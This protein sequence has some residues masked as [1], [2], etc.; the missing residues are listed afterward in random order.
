[1]SEQ[2]LEKFHAIEFGL[3]YTFNEGVS[4]AVVETVNRDCPELFAARVTTDH[5]A[6]DGSIIQKSYTTIMYKG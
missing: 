5:V 4:I 2:M 1:M 3:G 6:K